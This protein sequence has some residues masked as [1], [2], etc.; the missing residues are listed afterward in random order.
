MGAAPANIHA[1]IRE[2]IADRT[3][4]FAREAALQE[5]AIPFAWPG[6]RVLA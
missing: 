2:N 6:T 1:F 3:L 4:R 5:D